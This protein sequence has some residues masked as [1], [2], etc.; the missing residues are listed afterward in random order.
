MDSDTVL[1]LLNS[2]LQ[3]H[4]TVFFQAV[5]WTGDKMTLTFFSEVQV[6]QL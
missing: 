3:L 4:N 6:E 2:V 1:Q 5:V